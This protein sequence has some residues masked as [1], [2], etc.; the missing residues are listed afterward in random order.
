MS[1]KQV[2]DIVISE[3]PVSANVTL[4]AAGA[5]EI[6]IHQGGFPT[7]RDGKVIGGIGVGGSASAE[8]ERFAKAGLDAL[9]AK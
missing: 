7:M 5:H 3:K 4:I 1:T 2:E 8:D 6:T 9:A